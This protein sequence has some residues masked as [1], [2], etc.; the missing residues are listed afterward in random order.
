MMSRTIP[1]ERI[2]D[3]GIIAHID[4]GK[5]TITEMILHHS[6]RTYKIGRV[7]DGTAE[8]DWM[9]QERERGITITAAATSCDWQDH[10][11]NIIDTPGHVD[12]TAEVE[13]S[14]RV[15]DGGVMIFDGV[16]GV[17]SQSEMV[18]RQANKYRVPRICFVNKMDRM[19]ADLWRTVD[20]MK[21]RLNANVGLTQLPLGEESSLTGVIDI[22]EEKAYKFSGE[23]NSELTEIP[24]PDEYRDNAARYRRA[25]IENLA[26]ADDEIML[27]Y[28]ADEEID[29]AAIKAGLRRATI[30]ARIVPVLCGSAL[31]NIGI[32]PVLNAIVDY[33]PSP[34][35][36]PPIRG[37]GVR[38]QGSGV[39]EELR[40]PD[41]DAPFSALA[42][43]IVT[44]PFIGRL[45]YL[46][47]Y[48]GRIKSGAVVYNAVTGKKERIG[49]LYQM[50]ANNRVEIP[51]IDSGSI[52]AAVGLRNTSTGDTICDAEHPIILESI[53]FPE[54]VI[55]VAIEP[56]SRGDQDRIV[57]ALTK[58]AEEDPT[59]KVQYNQETGQTLISGMG[60]LQLE[61]IVVRLLREFKVKAKVSRPRVAYK[62]TITIPA[63]AEGRF[64][65]Q[66]GGRGQYGHV[67]LEIEP[68]QPG[69]GF[70]FVNRIQGGVVPREYIPAVQT[71]IKQTF[72]EGVIA[73]YPVVDVRATIVDGSYHEVDSSE[74]AFKM[75][76]AIAARECV[77]K[78]APVIL[79]PIMKLEVTTP[80]EFLGDVIGGLNARR[81]NIDGI[82]PREA[83]T[84]IQC[85]LPLAESFGYATDLRSISQGRASFFM[86]F[87][88]YQAVSKELADSIIGKYR[89]G[90]SG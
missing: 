13:R 52:A 48:S 55:S 5:T 19:G 58:L 37:S 40:Y 16:A 64:V 36:M 66:T 2:R 59:F 10:R 17:E 39:I 89:S 6:G 15:L 35:D 3:I 21:K 68:L 18:W 90:N 8:M 20:M 30:S 56:M 45:V 4:A 26:E 61:V 74:P 86:G 12:F 63:R 70:E 69:T 24:I 73:G 65:R 27:A 84:V 85:F 14:L 87:D 47:V 43:K 22:I 7:D 33:L 80:Q 79:E 9:D 78:A 46:R 67:W 25:L 42:F 82:E 83:L 71:G 11:I 38:G 41:D 51:E 49:R 88:R 29:V 75:A 31:R 23:L 34:L 81:G 62:E 32:Q 72:A 57:D 1:L 60:E 28:V 44:D 76:G 54:P 77:R 50:H 53:T